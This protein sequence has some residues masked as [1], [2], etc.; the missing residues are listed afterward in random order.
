MQIRKR[1]GIAVL[2]TRILMLSVASLSL[3]SNRKIYDISGIIIRICTF[4]T[5]N[6]IRQVSGMYK[7][8][9]ISRAKVYLQSSIKQKACFSS[10]DISTQ[11]NESGDIT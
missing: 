7:G 10:A 5:P 2:K 3:T 4:R 8:R 11:A 9:F 6:A 1:V